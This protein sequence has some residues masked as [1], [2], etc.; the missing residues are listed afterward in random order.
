M[1][2]RSFKVDVSNQSSYLI[3]RQKGSSVCSG[4]WT[5]GWGAPPSTIGSGTSIGFQGESTAVFGGTEA[6]IKFDAIDGGGNRHGELYVYWNNPYYGATRFKAAIVHGDVTPDC[7][8]G[9]SEFDTNDAQAPDFT[10]SW[11]MGDLDGNDGVTEPIT[12]G[13]LFN[14]VWSTGTGVLAGIPAL[15]GTE[16]VVAH[17]HLAITIQDVQTPGYT[18]TSYTYNPASNP[19]VADWIRHWSADDVDIQISR[20]EGDVLTFKLKDNL[21][22]PAL[23]IAADVDVSQRTIK[24]LER[25]TSELLSDS[26]KTMTEKQIGTLKSALDRALSAGNLPKSAVELKAHLSHALASNQDFKKEAISVSILDHITGHLIAPLFA[27]AVV[28]LGSG[29]SLS[30]M[31]CF[32]NG[33]PNGLTVRY[34]RVVGGQVLR[35]VEARTYSP[36]PR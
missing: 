3:L 1:P 11:N 24:S 33:Y 22:T 10:G 13:N 18:T 8:Q 21:S 30:L 26:S 5:D 12:S 19:L 6:W 28:G 4:G 20:K 17:A 15:L 27:R 34:Q 29:V 16:N 35:D 36:P 32:A 23:S 9:T 2:V 14:A 7:N 31:Q 25:Q